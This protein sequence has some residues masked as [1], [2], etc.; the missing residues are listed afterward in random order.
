MTN[1]Y[2]LLINSINIKQ[3]SMFRQNKLQRVINQ[4]DLKVRTMIFENYQALTETQ[5]K[6]VW[7][8]F[9]SSIKATVQRIKKMELDNNS[10]TYPLDRTVEVSQDVQL[11]N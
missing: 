8:L 5:M 9:H 6:S 2:I 7:L 1:E 4:R 10:L 11:N 3:K